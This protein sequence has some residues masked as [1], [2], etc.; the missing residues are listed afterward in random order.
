MHRVIGVI[1]QRPFLLTTLNRDMEVSVRE[2]LNPRARAD[3]KLKALFRLGCTPLGQLID[4]EAFTLPQLL[5]LW[6]AIVALCNARSNDMWSV[7]R[8]ADAY[9]AHMRALGYVVNQEQLAEQVSCPMI[10]PPT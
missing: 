9:V 10:R 4:V 7:Q 2:G 8:M 3:V 6:N 1:K 5:T